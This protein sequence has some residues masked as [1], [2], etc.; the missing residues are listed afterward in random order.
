METLQEG[1]GARLR[2]W[3]VCNMQ[4]QEQHLRRCRH[5]NYVDLEDPTR[6]A[7]GRHASDGISGWTGS[8]GHPS[9][10]HPRVRPPAD[11]TMLQG[12][13]GALMPRGYGYCTSKSMNAPRG[14]RYK[15]R[16][17]RG[18]VT[19]GSAATSLGAIRGNARRSEIGGCSKWHTGLR[20]ENSY[21]SA[22]L[23][24]YARGSLTR[25]DAAAAAAG[26]SPQRMDASTLRPQ[27]TA[28]RRSMP[29]SRTA[30]VWS[31]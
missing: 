25:Q 29:W 1:K 16:T 18:G 22:S 8:P 13:Q 21:T 5:P 9:P 10:R 28:T 30:P 2:G 14:P 3:P 17:P 24:R 4:P 19:D 31:T 6:R 7:A 27:W 12:T 11:G 26:S 23:H 15:R 20:H